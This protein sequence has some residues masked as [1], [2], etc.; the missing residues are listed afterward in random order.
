MS[1]AIAE[2]ERDLRIA[3]TILEWESG[4]IFGHIG[5]RLSGGKGVACKAFRPAS[6]EEPDWLVHFDWEVKKTGG[7]GTPPMEW[8][9]YTEIFAARPDVQAIA[10]T[11]MPACIALSLAGHDIPP[12]HMQS[13]KFVRTIPTYPRPI[14]I[15]DRDEGRALAETL[16]DG[17]AVVIRGHGIVS[18]GA[19][20][21]EAC[22]NNLY[23]ERT[24]K[25]LGMAKAHGYEGPD[26]D[27]IA[28]MV[29]SRQALTTEGD[30]GQHRQRRRGH[31][32]EWLY[33][34]HKIAEGERWTRGWS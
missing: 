21:D 2:L 15:K 20:I 22:M 26:S 29:G 11:H 9:I 14:H 5:V 10:H 12:V 25:I 33:Y 18:V 27:F 6:P 7:T 34:S 4:D 30:A 1:N 8:P 19:S 32:N 24:A 16:G 23:L 17:K 3:A 13:A 31:S 28:E